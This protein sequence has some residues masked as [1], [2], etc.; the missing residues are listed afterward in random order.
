MDER[1]DVPWR[2]Q[3]IVGRGWEA[4]ERAANPPTIARRPTP[5]SGEMHLRCAVT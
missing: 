3:Y 4:G 2:D 1:E 5:S